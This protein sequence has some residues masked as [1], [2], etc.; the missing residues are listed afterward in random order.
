MSRW[1]KC[2]G[3]VR[4]SANVPNKSSVYADEGTQAHELAE[5]AIRA[6]AEGLNFSKSGYPDEM[7]SAV[8]VYFEFFVSEVF[9]KEAIWKIEH[10]FD[11]AEIYPGLF[12]TCDLVA[13]YPQERLL[14]VV[15]YKHGAGIAVEVKNNRQL[16]YYAL[17]A[18]TT[19]KDVTKVGYKPKEV[20]LVIVQPRCPHEDGPIR[21]WRIDV[22]EIYDF[23]LDLVAAAKRTEEKD[24]PL[25][26]GDHC[27]FCPASGMCPELN[28]KTMALAQT[29]FSPVAD[30]DPAK[31]GKT[32]ALLPMVENWVK[33]V[34]DFAYREAQHG[35]VPPGFK[36]VAKRATRKWASEEVVVKTL[37][38]IL[39]TE[40]M[41]ESK[42]KSPAQIEKILSKEHRSKI[43]QLTIS[44]S[45]GQTLVPDFDSRPSVSYDPKSLFSAVPGEQE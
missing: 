6:F 45:R 11:M 17:G 4:L 23:M 21:R 33:S 12:G 29:H 43:D 24:A 39:F 40:D 31:L 2:P 1:E 14:R 7:I 8:H 36:L 3:S 20:E 9:S 30:Y 28:Q 25:V 35:R 34:R 5:K 13:Y 27:R 22:T 10:A 42:L 32:L 26:S 16:L 41:Y 15:D 38:D 37:S 18:L 44:E 19:F